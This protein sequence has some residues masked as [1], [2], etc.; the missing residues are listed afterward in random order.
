MMDF[1]GR[2]TDEHVADALRLA[3]ASTMVEYSNYSYE[4]S[5]GR[6]TSAGRAD[7]EDYPVAERVADKLT[8]IVE[9]AQWYRGHRARG[10]RSCGKVHVESFF[11]GYRR[12]KRASVDLIVTSPPLRK[13]LPLQSEHPAAPILARFLRVAGGLETP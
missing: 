3:F 8:E 5:L 13:Q 11:D 2:Q 12:V 1:A 7:V 4:P 9:D 6:R 10:R